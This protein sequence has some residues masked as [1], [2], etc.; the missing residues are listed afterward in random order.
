M[1]WTQ[2]NEEK[3][4]VH[5]TKCLSQIWKVHPFRE[6]NTRTIIT[7]CC[8]F[9]VRNGTASESVKKASGFLRILTLFRQIRAKRRNSV[10]IRQKSGR[11]PADI[12]SVPSNPGKKTDG[13]PAWG[14]P[15]VYA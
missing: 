13:A 3:K 9:A 5:F 4:S 7:F 8:D 6:G 14:A 1:D 15:S 11:F 10:R 2:M 12:D